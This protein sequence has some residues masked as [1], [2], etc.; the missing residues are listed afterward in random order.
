MT[1]SMLAEKQIIEEA[2]RIATEAITNIRTVAGLR[3]EPH[4]I[5]Q[6]SNEILKVEKTIRKRL[7]YRGV[8]NSC[9]QFFPFFGYA[10]ALCYGGV[11]VS[12]K[13]VNFQDIIKYKKNKNLLIYF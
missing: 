2:S 3:R 1:E 13:A 8:V 10:C 12:E 5:S 9:G 4:L 7:K 11:L 6:Y